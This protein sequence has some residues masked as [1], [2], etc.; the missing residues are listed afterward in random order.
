MHPDD[1][2]ATR[3]SLISTSRTNKRNSFVRWN[4][5]FKPS[6][7]RP[8]GVLEGL[9]RS[10]AR[11]R[12]VVDVDATCTCFLLLSHNSACVPH[13]SW[14]HHVDDEPTMNGTSW[15]HSGAPTMAHGASNARALSPLIASTRARA[16]DGAKSHRKRRSIVRDGATWAAARGARALG[17]GAIPGGEYSANTTDALTGVNE[18][19]MNAGKVTNEKPQDVGRAA[20]YMR[21][22]I[23]SQVNANHL[24]RAGSITDSSVLRRKGRLKEQDALIEFIVGLHNTH[25]TEE[26][27]TKVE[28]W[29]DEVIALPKEKR[30]FSRLSRMVPAVGF[31]FHRLPLL[32]ALRE[33]DE[34]SSLSKRKYVLP[35][36]AEVRHILNIAQVHASSK[37]VRLVT[38]DADGTLYADGMHFEDDNKMI[39]KIMQLMELG[40]HVAIVTA[41]G[42]PGEPSRFE[43]RLKGL[44]D[45]FR[46]QE[47]P[48]EVRDRFHVMGGEC[49][50]LLRVNDAYRLEFV[51]AQE[52]HT[53]QM[54]DWRQNKEVASFLDRAEE[55]LTSYA[56]HLGVEVDV[57][58]KEYAVGVLPKSDT[59]YENLEEMALACQAELSD[60]SIPFCAFNGGNDVFV[61]VGNKH[62]GLQA[63]MRYLNI[64]GS[65]T[66]HVGDRFTLT[67][68]D[69]KV[70]E[71]A[72]ILWVASPDETT[73]F[74]RLLYRDILN[75]RI[76]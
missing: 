1:S 43:G 10:R 63:L 72:S 19:D 23:K 71:A 60:A 52:W 48:K 51:P 38:F 37:D 4:D 55:F 32:K 22:L 21:E 50:Y 12:V 41:A 7:R 54:Y 5:S 62:I 73:F 65:Q 26:V 59:I 56:S 28:R 20:R 25:T 49:N 17:L 9:P 15:R 18:E 34:F 42:Y 47:L 29:I 11:L 14:R 76:L 39:D 44:V 75:A 69:A 68:N 24:A 36:F 30:K 27:F 45:A 61:D 66:L 46:A 31:F 58:R 40:I 53:D 6:S 33:Y 64:D 74:M 16:S 2:T 3:V 8:V 35:N 13:A 57:L 67:G 70:R